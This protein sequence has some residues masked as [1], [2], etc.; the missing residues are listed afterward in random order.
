M[1]NSLNRFVPEGFKPFKSSHDYKLNKPQTVPEKQT[2]NGVKML[3][4]Y[5][6][7]F[8]ELGIKDGY[9]LSFHHHLRNGD[10]AYQSK[11]E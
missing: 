2:S 9:T 5:S 3:E 10:Y 4:S 1:K 8:D 6:Q 7:M 11:G